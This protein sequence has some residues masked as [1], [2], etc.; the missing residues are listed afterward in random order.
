MQHETSGIFAAA[1][2]GPRGWDRQGRPGAP[3]GSLLRN[4]L[5]DVEV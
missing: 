5:G 4:A 1:Y 2:D 3:P